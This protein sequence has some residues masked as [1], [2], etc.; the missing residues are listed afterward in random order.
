MILVTGGTG[1]VGKELTA[2]LRMAGH[3]VRVL[4]RRPDAHRDWARKLGVELVAGDVTAPGSL[5][6]ACQGI[7]T[8]IH[9]VGIIAERGR[10]TYEKVHVEGTA[11]LLAEAR[12]S[13]VSRW[14]QMSAA[15]TRTHA[16]S[17][18]H[19]TK[20]AA[21][22]LVR[23]SGLT[24]TILRPSLI[25]GPGDRFTCLFARMLEF[26]WN[27]LNTWSVPCLGGGKTVFQPVAVGEV[28]EAFARCVSYDAT[29]GRTLDVCGEPV[30]FFG[31]V[32]AIAKARGYRPYILDVP[33][34]VVFLYLPF[35]ALFKGRPVLF[36][37]PLVAS[38]IIAFLIQLHL[39][40]GRCV[41]RKLGSER[42]FDAALDLLGPAFEL[43]DDQV[44]MLS[45]DQH[46]NPD[47]LRQ[48]LE[49]TPV[50]FAEGIRRYLAP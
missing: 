13:G 29:F 21:E 31:V 30:N 33:L 10:S 45:E 40:I 14:I 49:I 36:P 20:W 24:W 6:G 35:A 4:A 5:D 8:V 16:V 42:T 2:R 17:R 28:A 19:Q 26:P 18:Y 27:I 38:R 41:A 22:E 23:E 25:Y 15:G 1:F 32:E 50:P 46:G 44:I 12:K 3:Q 37:V 34:D 43:N 7:H 11:H 9:L 48:L 39:G 47:H